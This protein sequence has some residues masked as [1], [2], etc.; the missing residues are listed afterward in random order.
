VRS[1]LENGAWHTLDEV[2][3]TQDLAAAEA[4]EGF[5]GVF[6][7]A[8]Q[9]LGRGR[10]GRGWVSSAGDSLTMSLAFTAYA[11]HPR[12]YLV[13]MTV[14]VAAAAV[15]HCEI[16]WP[17]DLVADGRKLGGILTELVADQEGRRVPVVGVGINLNHKHVPPEIAEIADSVARY[18]GGSYV[19]L[20]IGEA[21]VERLSKMPEPDKWSDLAPVWNLFDHTPGKRYRTV[22]GREAIALGIG[23]EGQLMCSID[24]ETSSIMAAEAMFGK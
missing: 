24:G 20:K 13:G 5:G 3:S 11:D 14:A 1:P 22:D 12:P 23:P 7:A 2:L 4:R 8:N 6:F 19:P 18:S 16:A 21:I 15:L 9:T 17:N 10:F